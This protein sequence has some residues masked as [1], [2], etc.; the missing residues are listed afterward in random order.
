[1][2]LRI[3]RVSS[4][5]K[6]KKKRRKPRYPKGQTP[7]LHILKS[8]SCLLKD[9]DTY[10]IMAYMYVGEKEAGFPQNRWEGIVI[11]KKD[12]ENTLADFESR[13]GEEWKWPGIEGFQIKYRNAILCRQGRN[14]LSLRMKKALPWKEFYEGLRTNQLTNRW[15]TDGYVLDDGTPFELENDEN[16]ILSLKGRRFSRIREKKE[17]RFS[18]L[19]PKRII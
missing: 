2:K 13:Y 5:S 3:Y 12:L 16:K 10:L 7:C 8:A 9:N 17:P 15:P 18:K 6:K 4:S 1:M 11:S 14:W 19:P